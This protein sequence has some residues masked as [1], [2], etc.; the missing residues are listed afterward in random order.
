MANM[1]TT[2]LSYAAIGWPVFP[3]RAAEGH[4]PET[5]EV[6]K[7]KI[8]HTSNGL[9]AATRTERIIREWWRRNP[10]AIVGGPTG[11]PMGAWV[12]D[13]DEK[14]GV[15]S[16][17]GWLE[18]MEAL[19]GPLPA[20]RRATTA[21][22]GMHIYFN[23]VDGVRNRG[24]MDL[25]VDCR[26]QGGYVI[27][28]GSAM[29]DGRRYDWVDPDVPIADAPQ[30]LL[31]MVL[32]KPFDPAVTTGYDGH[33]V[34][35]GENPDYV[36]AA[37]GHELDKLS[38]TPK[39]QRGYQLNASSFSIG[40]F[41]G[42]GAVSRADAEAE[43]Y[44]AAQANGSVRTDGDKE[45]RAKIK[46]GLDAGA[47]QPRQVPAPSYHADEAM[48]AEGARLASR[49]LANALSGRAVRVEG[50]HGDEDG[51]LSGTAPPQDANVGVLSAPVAPPPDNTIRATPFEWKDPASLPRRDFVYSTHLIR[52]YVS[53]TVAP[54]GL[55]KTSLSIAEALDMVTG[56]GLFGGAGPTSRKLR[57]WLA[58]LE[59]TRD[60]M[61]RRIMAA[62]IHYNIKP[63]DIGDRLFLD[64]G[65]E[66]GIVIAKDDKRGTI[67]ARPVVEQVIA[68]MLQNEID[69][70]I[71]DPFISSHGVD[72]NSNGA[73]DMVAKLWSQI[74]DDTN[75]AIEI[76]H[77]VR[78]TQD[79]KE[80]TVED[81]RGA[82]ALLAAA[83]SARALNRMSEAQ[84]ERASVGADERF[85]IFSISRGKANLAPMTARDEWRKLVSV[86]LGNGRGLTQPQ[87][88]APVVELWAW[89]SKEAVAE[90]V[91]A[92]VTPA[93]MEMVKVRVANTE[94]RVSDQSG[95]WAGYVIADALGWPCEV[96]KAKTPEK[97]RVA[98]LLSALLANGTLVVEG[99][100]DPK[101]PTRQVQV[102]RVA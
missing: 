44:S 49:L 22:G 93:Q 46:R 88:F 56:R 3:C 70:L 99:A 33:L 43:L 23:H 21:N 73:I 13:L 90:Q 83:R 86:P 7:E 87:D 37:V 57:V 26:G 24:G 1:L 5:G 29:A 78:K 72:E 40:Q 85:Q 16:G 77:H 66:R 34:S 81:G 48:A 10:D 8:P 75:S 54:G 45:T 30:W 4:D 19:H 91:V 39:G 20:T 27:L 12:L 80:V 58:N 60:E 31:D 32:P 53:V 74:A 42:S 51:T 62:C 52:R 95:Q 65:R 41:V 18:R 6:L 69:V 68:T 55:G 97:G 61:E 96:S 100:T 11:T 9:K 79:G 35:A 76:I 59:D 101:H 89:P 98:A 36:N 47:Q 71:L 82:G 17:R 38:S 63:E 64:V 2:A 84:A 102:V 50:N 15:G 67:V 28:P 94:C 14:P 92:E 25:A